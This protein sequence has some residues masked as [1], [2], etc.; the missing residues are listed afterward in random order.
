M[1]KK[2]IIFLIIPA[3]FVNFSLTSFAEPPL[4]ARKQTTLG[5]Y[6]TAKVAFE[7]WRADPDSVKIVDVRTP[8]EYIFVGHAPMAVNVPIKFLE[9]RFDSRN[10]KP[11]MHLNDGFVDEIQTMFSR[12]DTILLMCRSGSRSALAAN[13]LAEAG[14]K[15]VYNICD[16][17]E[18]DLLKIDGS[19]HNGRRILNGWRNSEAPWTYKVDPKLM[20]IR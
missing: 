11:V 5:L 7:K 1:K 9:N 2:L 4:P 20:Y 12:S 10:N 19:Y 16:G 13:K 15:K 3:L 17:F 6:A 14:F 8:G 18:G